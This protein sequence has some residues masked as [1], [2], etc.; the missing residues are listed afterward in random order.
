MTEKVIDRE[1]AGFLILIIPVA[2]I[3]VLIFTA[4]KWILLATILLVAWK[5]WENYYWLQWSSRINPFF[6]A[7]IL[8]NQGKITP[9]DLAIPTSMSARAS[10]KFLEKK[11]A[12]FGAQK[13]E[14]SER[15]RIY[16]FLTSKA[17]D[18][19]FES[20]QPAEMLETSATLAPATSEPVSSLGKLLDLA[21]QREEAIAHPPSPLIIDAISEPA[22][23]PSTTP[24]S[25]SQSELAKRLETNSSTVGRRKLSQ[26]F[27]LWSASKDPEGMAWMFEPES[28]LFVSVQE[29]EE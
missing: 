11:A 27:P 7:L 18:G 9:M 16:Y 17:L 28:N 5:V 4:W 15:G 8:E 13:Q 25:L 29:E 22:E 19:I 2:A 26:D 12:E 1:T 24:H 20:S 23:L 10:E 21:E 3:L 14:T 6:H